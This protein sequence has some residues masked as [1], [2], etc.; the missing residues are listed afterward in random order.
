[1]VEEGKDLRS[2]EGADVFLEEGVG[3]WD[4]LG[5][6]HCIVIVEE[7]VRKGKR[8]KIPTIRL[9]HAIFEIMYI[10]TPI[11]PFPSTFSRLNCN[12]HSLRKQRSSFIEIHYIKN[13][14]TPPFVLY[15]KVKPLRVA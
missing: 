13:Y 11:F 6:E 1:M 8:V 10:V 12:F 9:Y 5:E 3:V 2:F 4:T 14:P 15:T 7:C